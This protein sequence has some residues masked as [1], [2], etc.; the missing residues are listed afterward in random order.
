MPIPNTGCACLM[1]AHEVRELLEGCTSPSGR[2]GCR[3]VSASVRRVRTHESLP[4]ATLAIAIPSRSIA[5][6]PMRVPGDRR[7][8][9]RRRPP[10]NS[11]LGLPHAARAAM[12]AAR[13]CRKGF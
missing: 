3:K 10:L 2:C 13:V 12:P 8:R 4:H 11:A 1:A 5:L 7:G 9:C 6:T